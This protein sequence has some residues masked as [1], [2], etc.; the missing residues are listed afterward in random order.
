[1]SYARHTIASPEDFHRAIKPAPN[2]GDPTPEDWAKRSAEAAGVTSPV[3]Q[4]WLET[5][6]V[7]I[8]VASSAAPADKGP[9]AADPAAGWHAAIT[10][11]DRI[12]AVRPPVLDPGRP[13]ASPPIIE[14]VEP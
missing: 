14:R 7:P 5:F 3:A 1:M 10:R 6:A 4:S 9:V 2:S 8:G 12:E 13:L 11:A